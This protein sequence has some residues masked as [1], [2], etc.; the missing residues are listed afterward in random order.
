MSIE[1]YWIQ[2]GKPKTI[3]DPQ[4]IEM[5]LNK[6]ISKTNGNLNLD[7]IHNNEFSD[8][9]VRIERD[10][11]LFKLYWKD[12]KKIFDK[13]KIDS[14]TENEIEEVIINGRF[15]FIYYLMD[16]H[17]ISIDIWPER[18]LYVIF[19]CN[20]LP[21]KTAI[22][23]LKKIF[24]FENFDSEN[25]EIKET[26]RRIFFCDNNN[27]KHECVIDILPISNS[28]LFQKIKPWNTG[29]SQAILKLTTLT[30]II[31]PIYNNKQQFSK[32][33]DDDDKI[34]SMISDLRYSLEGLIKFYFI[35]KAIEIGMDEA[36]SV[37][38]NSVITDI[39]IKFGY[40]MLSDLK[41]G[42][43]LMGINLE[44]SFIND[45]NTYSHYS[46]CFPT[47][48]TLFECH[49]KY[50]NTLEDLFDLSEY[51]IKID[52]LRYNNE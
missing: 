19:H 42:L 26:R 49:E 9:I 21:Q 28:I 25:I 22:K 40:N 29:T 3:Y 12:Y 47:K 45:L 44:Q 6:F 23:Y 50:C 13:Q 17:K 34:R 10:G 11:S 31:N 38:W 33:T 39:I 32:L 16:I 51:K 46:G 2:I 1:E 43:N 15:T 41:R 30:E 52:L 18:G 27:Y 5:F 14:A 24:L 36:N 7:T 35:T 48:T 4:Q 20:Y 37:S 8:N